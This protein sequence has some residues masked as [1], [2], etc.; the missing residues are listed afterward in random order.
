MAY[1][2]SLT[3]CISPPPKRKA[4]ATGVAD[5]TRVG[6]GADAQGAEGDIGIKADKVMLLDANPTLAAIESGQA[7]IRDHL[8]YF[9]KHFERVLRP[10][11]SPRL[12]IDDFRL[13]YKRN[14]HPQ[15]RHFVVHQHDH[16][17]SGTTGFWFPV[18]DEL[19]NLIE[20][21]SHATGSLLIWDT[22]EYEVLDRPPQ[23]SNRATDD[24]TSDVEGNLSGAVQSQ[25]ERLFAAFQSRHIHLRLNGR[26]LPL[27]YTIAMR[28]PSQDATRRPRTTRIKRQRMEPVETVKR[29]KNRTAAADTESDSETSSATTTQTQAALADAA[30]ASEPEDERQDVEI[31]TS[32][33]YP[34]AA[35]TIGS[36][37]QRHWLVTIDRKLSGFRKSSRR[38]GSDKERWVGSWEPFHVKGKDCERSVVTGRLAEDVMADE[39]IKGFV[40]RGNWRAILETTC[41][42]NLLSP[43][44]RQLQQL[45]FQTDTYCWSPWH[46]L[47]KSGSSFGAFEKL[48]RLPFPPPVKFNYAHGAARTGP[49]S[50]IEK[51]PSEL[52]SLILSEKGMT[53]TDVIAFGLCSTELW[54]QAVFHI[55]R[56]VR[57]NTAPWAGRPLLCS[58]SWLTTLPPPIYERYPEEIE[59]ERKYQ[60]VLAQKHVPVPGTATG[61]G[62]RGR[63]AWYGPCPARVWNWTAVSEYENVRGTDCRQKW[64]EA[65]TINMVDARLSPT[66]SNKIWSDIHMVL[67]NRAP[68]EA[69]NWILLNATTQQYVQLK[70]RRSEPGQSPQLYVAGARW[71]G[72]DQAL[73]LRIC[74]GPDAIE[75]H[76]LHRGVWAGHCFE[77]IEDTGA[78]AG[79]EDVTSKIVEEGK[80]ARDDRM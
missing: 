24:E 37:H 30:L 71:L 42:W 11:R 73:I 56:D 66:A 40:G 15:G 22:G 77:V 4:S 14:Q 74:W 28:L 32:N 21:A 63:S 67:N 78:R 31:R 8:E 23:R 41:L 26:R 17:I 61:R 44:T 75:T 54:A 34:G 47:H 49:M 72:L 57:D 76:G 59:A 38:G 69:N 48:A 80:A 3:R 53:N 68:I 20:S 50:F 46:F 25:S 70:L 12:S 16:P 7:Q 27:G 36:I 13:L 64:L 58:G 55:Q 1:P 2:A 60:T 19:N 29:A 5:L 10:P 35:N 18:V 65:L 52:I 6:D 39:G 33:A 9:A 62:S 45:L 79:G 43:S 51:V